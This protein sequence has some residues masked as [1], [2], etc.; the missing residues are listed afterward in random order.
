MFDMRVIHNVI[1]FNYQG[2]KHFLHVRKL[3]AKEGAPI[4]RAMSESEKFPFNAVASLTKERTQEANRDMDEKIQNY[5]FTGP[6]GSVD[7]VC[8]IDEAELLTI[9]STPLYVVFF[10][11][12]MGFAT[13]TNTSLI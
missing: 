1:L 2:F 10:L 7:A 12:K 6:L 8:P 9:Y 4:W 3:P 11:R 5:P 13:C